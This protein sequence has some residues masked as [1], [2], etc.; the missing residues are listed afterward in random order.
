MAT[1]YLSPGKSVDKARK[2]DCIG[3]SWTFNEPTL[4]F[5]YTLD[6]AKL[7]KQQGLLTNYVT[8]GFITPEAF[9]QLMPYLDVYRVD[10]KGFSDSTYQRIGHH[11]GWKGIL[12]V[13]QEAKEC[14]IH[15]EV[16]TNIIPGV[17]DDPAELRDI[18]TWIRERLG[19][20]TP[21]HVTAYRPEYR[22]D[23]PGPTPAATLLRATEIGRS[24]GLRHVY[25]GNMPGR[26]EGTE[27]TLCPSCSMI[28]IERQGFTIRAN[29]LDG[30][31]CPSCGAVIAGRWNC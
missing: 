17:N 30:N 12:S 20:D 24:R 15:V 31:R 22:M 23:E 27:N 18:A 8:N 9:E 5:E 11:K 26:V 3:I 4:W 10:I 29:H 7:A 14:G 13:T 28:L 6:A 25:A 16:V 19:P 1:S 21:W 2:Y